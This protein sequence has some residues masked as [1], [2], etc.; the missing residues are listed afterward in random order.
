MAEAVN[1]QNIN[2][3]FALNPIQNGDDYKNK[4]GNDNISVFHWTVKIFQASWE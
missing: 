3:Q 1:F 2:P 4:T